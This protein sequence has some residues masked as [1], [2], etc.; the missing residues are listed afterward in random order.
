MKTAARRR[1]A[2]GRPS[3]CHA[4]RAAR[5][6]RR[7]R[8]RQRDRHWQWRP[9]RQ[10]GVFSIATPLFFPV[11]KNDDGAVTVPP[12]DE[13][14][15]LRAITPDPAKERSARPFGPWVAAKLA[16]AP[17]P[18]KNTRWC[19]LGARE[20]ALGYDRSVAQTWRGRGSG[21]CGEEL[22]PLQHREMKL[23]GCFAGRVVLEVSWKYANVPA[24]TQA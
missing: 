16:T 3:N 19:L 7:R 14:A 1:P 13:A 9:A 18:V 23:S 2:R 24:P 12:A 5:Q 8:R 11:C 4:A 21:R 6:D 17:S 15:V 10:C 22:I 20:C